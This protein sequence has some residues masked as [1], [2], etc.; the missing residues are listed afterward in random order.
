[1]SSCTYG[2]VGV[3]RRGGLVPYRVGEAVLS[4]GWCEGCWVHHVRGLHTP[5]EWHHRAGL[6]ET[7][8]HQKQGKTV[9]MLV[10]QKT[11]KTRMQLNFC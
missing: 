6:Q 5:V 11:A 1:M 8:P 2:R 7:K 3:R 9:K 10:A 4:H